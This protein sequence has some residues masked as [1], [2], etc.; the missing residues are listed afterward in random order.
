MNSSSKDVNRRVLAIQAKK[1]RH[2]PNKKKDKQPSATSLGKVQNL[3]P[4]QKKFT[5]EFDVLGSLGTY[6][7]VNAI[8]ELPNVFFTTL[9]VVRKLRSLLF[10]VG[11]RVIMVVTLLSNSV[12]KSVKEG[13]FWWLLR[14]IRHK[15]I[16]LMW[17]SCLV[18]N[19]TSESGV[20]LMK[21]WIPGVQQNQGPSYWMKLKWL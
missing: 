21:S 17:K 10:C 6:W 9:W 3:V 20:G 16:A 4:N 19:P 13:I 1:K 14:K 18:F 7:G 5:C 2:K 12:R 15:Y 11:F 8:H